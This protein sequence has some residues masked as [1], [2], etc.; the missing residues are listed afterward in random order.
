MDTIQEIIQQKWPDISGLYSDNKMLEIHQ[1]EARFDFGKRIVQLLNT[2]YCIKGKHWCLMVKYPGE[3]FQLYDSDIESTSLQNDT[4]YPDIL[5]M[6]FAYHSSGPCISVYKMNSNDV[7]NMYFNEQA[8]QCANGEP[9]TIDAS[10]CICNNYTTTDVKFTYLCTKCQ[11]WFHQ[12]CRPNIRQECIKESWSCDECD[13]EWLC[14]LNIDTSNPE[15]NNNAITHIDIEKTIETHFKTETK[16]GF[17]LIYDI[18]LGRK[19]M[20]HSCLAVH[21]QR[22][23]KFFVYDYEKHEMKY[24][25]THDLEVA[26]V[27]LCWPEVLKDG[28]INIDIMKCTQQSNDSDCG[29]LTGLNAIHWSSKNS[30]PSDYLQGRPSKEL[31][32]MVQDFI[33]GKPHKIPMI[34]GKREE[35]LASVKLNPK[36]KAPLCKFESPLIIPSI[37]DMFKCFICQFWFHDACAG[38]KHGHFLS[39]YRQYCDYCED[40][41]QLNHKSAD[42]CSKMPD[43]QVC[44]IPSDDNFNRQDQA[45]HG[46]QSGMTMLFGQGPIKLSTTLCDPFTYLIYESNDDATPPGSPRKSATGSDSPEFSDWEQRYDKNSD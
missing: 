45:P 39:I 20:I 38:A 14:S 25:L 15:E 22:S 30:L 32:G 29:V 16:D 43:A 44:D 21:H 41:W 31:R 19:E 5:K 11:R 6:K 12:S 34:S 8:A 26:M 2:S 3:S 27:H 24:Q 1:N 13:K 36:C 23:S 17:I 18:N 42:S 9:T 37:V 33:S 46:N 40:F 28:G 10:C 35:V 7:W 4:D